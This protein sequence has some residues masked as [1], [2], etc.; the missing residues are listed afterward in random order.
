VGEVVLTIL[1]FAG[2]TGIALLVFG[3]WFLFAV[4]RGVVRLAARVLRGFA[5]PAPRPVPVQQRRGPVDPLESAQ[6]ATA[7]RG[8]WA[9][10][11]RDMVCGQ[12]MCRCANQPGARFCKR[13]GAPL[14]QAVTARRRV[15][16]L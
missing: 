7:A 6:Q 14:V 9:G 8:W 16:V 10:D 1:I 11:R 5:A 4:T 3:V 15:A 12:A 13:C 2:V